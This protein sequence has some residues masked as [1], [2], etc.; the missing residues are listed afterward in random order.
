MKM[1]KMSS[2][3]HCGSTI[4]PVEEYSPSLLDSSTS[5]TKSLISPQS[6]EDAEGMSEAIFSPSLLNSRERVTCHSTQIDSTKGVI[7]SNNTGANATD[8]SPTDL[9]SSDSSLS[10]SPTQ[11]ESPLNQP[12]PTLGIPP[13]DTQYLMQSINT[14]PMSPEIGMG[15]R[16]NLTTSLDES[17]FEDGHKKETIKSTDVGGTV[18]HVNLGGDDSTEMNSSVNTKLL[19]KAEEHASVSRTK[20][21]ALQR[22]KATKRPKQKTLTQTYL[23]VSGNIVNLEPWKEYIVTGEEHTA[24]KEKCAGGGESSGTL[25]SSLAV[26]KTTTEEEPQLKN[27]TSPKKMPTTPKTTSSPV[28]AKCRRVVTVVPQTPLPATSPSS[29]SKA[30][31]R[32]RSLMWK[33]RGRR[34]EPPQWDPEETYLPLSQLDCFRSRESVGEEIPFDPNG[35]K[36]L[37]KS[38]IFSNFVAHKQLKLIQCPSSHLPTVSDDS[39]AKV[40]QTLAPTC[41]SETVV[42]TKRTC[43]EGDCNSIING[44]SPPPAKKHAV[45]AQEGVDPAR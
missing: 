15:S 43:G 14:F 6:Q 13:S 31:P 24:S 39:S 17:H 16:K 37:G 19:L 45:E 41:A 25:A 12:P 35:R 4:S 32:G 2:I 36:E 42:A 30:S 23:K 34:A 26:W 27:A 7:N 11:L 3:L 28:A 21:L 33:N 1:E 38:N 18:M 40:Q 10:A 5:E 20:R 8:V 44:A 22:G 9:D 29:A